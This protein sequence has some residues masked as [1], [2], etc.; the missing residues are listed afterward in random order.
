MEKEQWKYLEKDNHIFKVSNL[1]RVVVFGSGSGNFIK[2][3]S[4]PKDF[5]KNGGHRDSHYLSTHGYYSHRLVAEAFLGDIEGMEVNHLNGNKFDN[6]LENL[7]I[8]TTKENMI[9]SWALGLRDSQKLLPVEIERKY[10][11]EDIKKIER[12]WYLLDR[13]FNKIVYSSNQEKLAKYIGVSRQTVNNS[14]RRATPIKNKYFICRERE[15]IELKK[16]Y[17]EKL[18]S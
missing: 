12:T 16:R 5:S 1:G 10:L 9:H 7:E 3:L 2:K 18:K 15:I 17:E 6:R 8:V 14:Y 13:D 4:E 11:I